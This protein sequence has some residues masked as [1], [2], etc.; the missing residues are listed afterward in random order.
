MNSGIYKIKNI[1]TGKFYIGSALDFTVR[2]RNHR[3]ELRTNKHA[4]KKLQ[5]AWNKYGERSFEFIAFFP[6][7]P[8]FLLKFEQMFLDRHWDK[9]ILYNINRYANNTLGYSHTEETKR[10]LSE[11]RKGIPLKLTAEQKRYNSEQMIRYNKE[12]HAKV[13]YF[14]TPQKQIIKIKNLKEFCRVNNLDYR[15]MQRVYSGERLSHKG[16][17][18]YW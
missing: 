8:E 2:F 9:R 14:V 3:Y 13:W 18:R 7:F 15:T 4:N 10:Y 6:C 1:Q 5:N 12:H 17:L 11:I 16:Y